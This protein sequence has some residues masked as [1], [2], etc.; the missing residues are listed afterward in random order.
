MLTSP[1]ALTDFGLCPVVV[2]RNFSLTPTLSQ[3]ERGFSGSLRLPLLLFPGVGF[4]SLDRGCRLH[5]AVLWLPLRKVAPFSSLS[6]PGLSRGLAF[7]T[8]DVSAQPERDFSSSGIGLRFVL[9]TRG[10]V[11]D[12]V[13]QLAFHASFSGPVTGTY[14][15]CET[16]RPDRLVSS[17]P[18]RGGGGVS[19]VPIR[20]S[21]SGRISGCAAVR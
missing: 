8:P 4:D 6:G 19:P 14:R 12:P 21:S 1:F 16:T 15:K 5:A 18:L 17:S 3:R 20:G 13:L 9:A 10:R 11:E 2:G 7:D